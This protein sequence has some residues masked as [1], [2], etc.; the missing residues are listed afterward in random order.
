MWLK[1]Y[2]AV[3]VAELC[4]VAGTPRGSF[5]HWWPSKQALA[6]SMLERR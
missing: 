4:E 1:G 2:G 6:V 3:G 5:Y